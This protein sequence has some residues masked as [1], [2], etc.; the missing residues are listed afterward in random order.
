MLKHHR[1][2]AFALTFILVISFSL[3]W[4]SA[5]EAEKPKPQDWQ[6]NGIIAALDDGYPEV[7]KLGFDKIAKYELKDFDPQK[8][9]NIAKKAVK[10]LND[11][12]ANSNVRISAASALGNLGNAAKPYIKDIADILKDKNIDPSVRSSATGVLGNLGDAAKPY[13]KDIADILNDVK[14]DF[15]LRVHAAEALGNL[16]ELAKPYA[17]NIGNIIQSRN[18]NSNV[19]AS[20]VGTLVNL[21]ESARP[22]LKDILNFIK[23]E[24]ADIY[25]RNSAALNFL[26]LGDM[27]KPYVKDILYFLKNQKTMNSVLIMAGDVRADASEVWENIGD[28]AIPYIKDI[29]D[30]LKDK[31][32]D[33]N[34]SDGAAT[35][36][37]KLGEAAKPYVKDIVD[38]LKDKNADSSVRGSAATALGNL[39]DLAKPYVKDI[40]D[41]FKDKNADSYV[42]GRAA[43]ALGN[44]GDLAKP[45]VKDIVDILKDEKINSSI[46]ANAVEALGNLGDLA[47]PYVKDIVDILKDEKIDSFIRANAVE[48]LG[49]LGDLA[50]PYVKDI[51]DILKDEKIDSSIHTNAVKALEKLG[52]IAKP[53]VKY[54]ADILKDKKIDASIHADAADVLG[55]LGDAAKPYVKDIADILKDKNVDPS[56]RGRAASALGNLE[57]L[58]VNNLVTV[59]DNIYYAGQSDRSRLI[60]GFEIISVFEDWRFYSYLLGGGSDDSKT[61]LKWVGLP[62]PKSIPTKLNRDE[63]IKTLEVFTKAWQP[64]QDLE[65]L[66]E[67]LAEKTSLV[68]SQK[69][70]TW[71]P[72]D[73]L[74]L[75]R[76]KNNLSKAGYGNKASAIESTIN[77]LQFWG[78]IYRARNIILLHIAFWLT[79]ILFYPKSPHIQA[80]FFWNPWVRRI[81]GMGYVGFLLTW[82]PYF[83][84]KLLEPF[85]FP[86]LADAGLDHFNP[87][88][89]FPESYVNTDPSPNL[90]PAGREAL[91]LAPLPLQGRGWGLGQDIGFMSISQSI[92]KI[93]GQI[94]IE[95]ASGLGK[96]MFLRHLLN[97]SSRTVVYLPA[98][99]CQ[100]GV[101]EAIQ[102]KLHG[103]AQDTDFLRSLIYS[104][105]IDI[106]IDGINEVNAETRAKICQFVETNFQ[107]NIIMTTQPL[108]WIAPATAK[109]YYIQPLTPDQVD[110]F[111]L[112][113]GCRL[114][115]DAPV[116]GKDYEEACKKFLKTVLDSSNLNSLKPGNQQSS[117]EIIATM[118]ILS[119]P[120]DLSLVSLMLS[121]NKEPNLFNLQQQQYNLMSAEYLRERGYEFPLKKFSQEVYQM[122]LNDES[123]LCADEFYKEL[124][125]ME[126][127]K[128]KMVVSRQWMQDDEDKIGHE[129]NKNMKEWYFRHDK[130]MEFFLVQNFLGNSD[131]IEARLLEHIGDSRFRGVYFLLA[132][133]LPLDDAKE[134]R[135][136]LIQYAADTKDHNVSDTF[137]QLL[138]SR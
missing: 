135:E 95:G 72:Q 99:K 100:K 50:K 109:T 75:E 76:L 25:V 17:E 59:L 118:R 107:G 133:L 18:N 130:I 34:V 129:L 38:I 132:N 101:I 79:L 68:V 64:S 80:I 14:L 74:L 119:N 20:A 138:R 36:L 116:Q 94:I 78:G 54:I 98:Q 16:G 127:E 96:T 92:P 111:L 6:I 33:S 28:L 5:K 137:V 120:M 24:N 56:V 13:I 108:E 69:Q 49:N 122:R 27:V 70:V 52:D 48:A 57:Q 63:A 136:E 88:A 112:S 40:V 35:A 3:P 82:V 124:E 42:H 123:A 15:S 12:N 9:D 62:K 31:N 26:Q 61:L 83:R 93:Q 126:D 86:L 46:R 71:Q 11:K 87:N 131:E 32:I 81:L 104:G 89:Y 7:Q 115:K 39:G 51:V 45:Y 30:I 105:A 73:I 106:C 77:S 58:Q 44:L 23:D 37:G 85:K 102:A 4:V 43:S 41:I 91:N 8:V 67:D 117:E 2:L 1:F 53:H 113:R 121:Q 65:R 134:L 19:R 47:K 22:Y 84:R 21:G 114:P 125:S 60:P 97:N 110:K 128:Y 90:S 103:Q 55:K 29:L 10:V 66:R